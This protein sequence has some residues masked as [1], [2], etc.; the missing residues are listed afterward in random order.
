MESPVLAENSNKIYQAYYFGKSYIQT[1]KGTQ[2]A[3]YYPNGEDCLHLN[4]WVNTNNTSTNKA[5]MA[6]FH[7]GSYKRGGTSDPLYDGYN[8]IEKFSD[9]ILV[10]VDFR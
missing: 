6:F 9:I 8:L 10:T 7:G 3:S 2:Y 4:I 5:V 1:E